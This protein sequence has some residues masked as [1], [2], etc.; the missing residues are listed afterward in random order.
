MRMLWHITHS[1]RLHCVVVYG[2]S[3]TEKVAPGDQPHSDYQEPTQGLLDKHVQFKR[4]YT[5]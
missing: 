5:C 2:S 4:Y 3:V 1:N